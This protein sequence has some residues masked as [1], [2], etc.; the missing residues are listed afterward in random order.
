MKVIYF[1]LDYTPHDYRF[2]SALAE[3]D[4]E[5]YY[6]RLQRG[7]RQTEDRPV[8]AKI[9]Q[10][11]WA[12][13][14]DAFRWRG[15]P[16]YVTGL[17]RIIRRIRPDLVHAGPIQ[18]CGLVAALA[19]FHPLLVMSW[20]FDL[21]QDADRNWL[22][23]A[24]TSYV[25]RFSDAFTSDCDATRRKAV[26]YGMDPARTT[27]FPWG[28]DLENFRPQNS[29]VRRPSFVVFCNRS[30]EPRYGV[31][32]LAKAFVT[33]AGRRSDVNLLLLG[34]GSQAQ[35]IRQ[36]LERGGVLERVTFA[37]QVSNRDLP[38]CYHMA[39]LYVSPSHVDGSSV[40]LMEALACGL[41]VVV[42]D[43][44]A[45]KE[46]VT[47][48]ADGWLFPDGDADALA[49]KILAAIESRKTLPKIGRAA[50]LTAEARADWKK[51][52][53]KLLE[54]YQIAAAR[55]KE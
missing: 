30:W 35:A 50:R 2:L 49:A 51:N 29:V 54:T 36:I 32:V 3:T 13:G 22:M 26:Q 7:P 19:G 31:D 14:R 5:I 10:V 47:D 34:G 52:F 27:V 44:P 24:I 45:N 40:S 21:M 6:V 16:K 20:G 25:L 39:D 37:G 15:L 38:R 42:S 9:E 46:W 18:T 17:R 28:V 8:P 11:Q 4:H 1:S 53:P 48:G 41:P 23:R 55:R 12:G 33:V 43:I